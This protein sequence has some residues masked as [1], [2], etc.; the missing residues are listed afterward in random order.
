VITKRDEK[1]IDFISSFHCA[2]SQ[3][4]SKLFFDNKLRQTQQRLSTLYNHKVVNRERLFYN[5][6]F[7]YFTKKSSQLRHFL[8]LS[9]FYATLRDIADIHNFAI[10]PT[11][12]EGIRP[13]AI[14]L[15]TIKDTNKKQLAFLEIEL[16]NKGVNISKYERLKMS[17]DYKKY[18]TL[19]PLVIFVTNKKIPKTDLSVLVINTDLTDINSLKG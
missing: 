12:I 6:E 5:K 17:G 16:S 8:I 10:E 15:F 19:F 7:V 9:D 2:R 18:F 13:D 11:N 1:V 3:T 4:I 14:T